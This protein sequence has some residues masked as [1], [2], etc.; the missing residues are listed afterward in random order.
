MTPREIA[1]R[2]LQFEED[3]LVPVG[4][5]LLQHVDFMAGVL[6]ISADQW[7][8]Q[9]RGNL[10]A[11][12]RKLGCHAIV[13]P[14][15]PKPPEQ[16][17]RDAHGRATMFRQRAA[18][19]D[20]LDDPEAVAADALRSPTPDQVRAQFDAA[21]ATAQFLRV[22]VQAQAEAGEMLVIPHTLGYA[23]A[24]PTST[25]TWT[26]EA[27][28]MACAAHPD[29]MRVVFDAWGARARCQC[30]VAARTIVAHSLPRLLWIGQDICDARGPVLSPALLERLYFPQI[31]R[32]L[33]PLR[34]AGIV[35]VWHA[36]ANY[37]AILPRLLELGIGGVQ[38]IFESPGGM[39]L[40]EVAALRTPE[41]RPLVIIGGM[42]THAVLPLGT[43][44]E[45][46]AA[47]DRCVELARARGGGLLI[48]PSGSVGPEASWPAGSCR[49]SSARFPETRTW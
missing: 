30:E 49:V 2:A 48:A 7:W 17:T 35:A 20:A 31:A 32:A 4:G 28:L 13:G 43:V 3:R 36:D 10:F 18:N 12:F 46:E 29:A 23:P 25:T 11:A 16:T 27:F 39:D 26:Y 38:G 37:R 19:P 6:G 33:E 14:S 8:A 44:A 1:L 9:P 45:V 47:A 22:S 21:E 34:D 15:M 41:G 5:G 40:E 42:T 24:F